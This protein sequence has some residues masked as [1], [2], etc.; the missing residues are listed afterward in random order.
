MTSRV[1]DHWF[2]GCTP[3]W[4][5]RDVLIVMVMSKRGL[6]KPGNLTIFDENTEYSNI[7][8]ELNIGEKTIHFILLFL[9]LQR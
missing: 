1:H 3:D 2:R 5:W 9:L 4:L 7:S 8:G 6:I